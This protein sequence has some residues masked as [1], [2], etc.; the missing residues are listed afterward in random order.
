MVHDG[1]DEIVAEMDRLG[2]RTVC[3]FTLEGVMGEETWGNDRVAE[4]IA[5]YPDR[6]VGFTLV[7]PVHGERVMLEE[8]QRRLT[9][10]FDRRSAGPVPT[11]GALQA[12]AAA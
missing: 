10:P 12:G 9:A 6:F 3:V 4:V 1:I 8:L 2:L 7:N 5:R 11:G